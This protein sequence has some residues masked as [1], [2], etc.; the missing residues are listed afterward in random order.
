MSYTSSALDSQLLCA[1]GV[2]YQVG[3]SSPLN[4]EP[5]YSGAGFTTTNIPAVIHG[6]LPHTSACIIGQISGNIVVAF[7]GTEAIQINDW[8]TDLMGEPVAT[9][10]FPGKVH[11]GF[12]LSLMEIMPHIIKTLEGLLAQNAQTPIVITGHSKGGGMASLA[13]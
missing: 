10:E 13:A 11:S 6:R 8:S 5:Y 1:C 2:S 12:Y 3:T 9:K 7:R 4:T